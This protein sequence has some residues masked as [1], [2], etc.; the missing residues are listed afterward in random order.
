[1]NWTKK[2]SQCHHQKVTS[3]VHNFCSWGSVRARAL[4]GKLPKSSPHLHLPLI[5]LKEAQKK[6]NL[7]L[8]SW[9]FFIC[10]T[11]SCPYP[12]H[13]RRASCGHSCLKYSI[14]FYCSAAVILAI[15][16]ICYLTRIFGYLEA[17]PGVQFSNGTPVVTEGL[18][19]EMEMLPTSV[20]M[21]LNG[22][23]ETTVKSELLNIVSTTLSTVMTTESPTGTSNFQ[24]WKPSNF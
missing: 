9:P 5:K 18:Q 11:N 19:E 3:I 17:M 10:L 1:M 7:S 4:I 2:I 15:C 22:N 14:L 23:N 8:I 13:R 6:I 21:L 20:P 16:F 12:Y 24:L